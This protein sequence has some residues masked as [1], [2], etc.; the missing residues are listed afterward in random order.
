[1]PLKEN[2]WYHIYDE[3]SRCMDQFR[4]LEKLIGRKKRKKNQAFPGLPYT[5]DVVKWSLIKH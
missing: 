4:F 1:M 5:N 2:H 3:I